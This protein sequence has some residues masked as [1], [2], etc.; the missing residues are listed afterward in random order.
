[1][2]PKPFLAACVAAAS[3]TGC[4]DTDPS[5]LVSQPLTNVSAR[6]VRRE[7][8]EAVDAARQFTAENKERF[9][10]STE[11]KLKECGQKIADF[12]AKLAT[13]AYDYNAKAEGTK[14]LDALREKRTQLGQQLEKL[15]QCSEEAWQDAKT[16]VESAAA[17]VDKTYEHAKSRFK[18]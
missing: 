3:L 12:D 11:A 2:K 15:R 5:D 14:A 1:M 4:A 8:R 6:E 17:E 7:T 16:A 13:L 18:D 9:L 10:A